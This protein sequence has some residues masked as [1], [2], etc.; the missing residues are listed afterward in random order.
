MGGQG[1]QR[2]QEI[3]PAHRKRLHGAHQ[4]I[5]RLTALSS[6]YNSIS[7][8]LEK[9]SSTLGY[10]K[11][12]T[13]K[14]RSATAIAAGGGEEAASDDKDGRTYLVYNGEGRVSG[15]ALA[16]ERAAYSNW[17]GKN[18]DPDAV[19]RHQHQLRRAGFRDNTHAKGGIF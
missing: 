13:P 11:M 14:R 7:K 3:G 18:L 2:V 12:I 19:R 15:E 8:L 1:G 6:L 17:D 9:A 16:R 10:L 4:A 5:L